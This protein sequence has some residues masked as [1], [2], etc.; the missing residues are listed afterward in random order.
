M[1]RFVIRSSTL[2]CTF[3][4]VSCSVKW[5]EIG[6]RYTGLPKDLRNV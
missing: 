1:F 4:D 3:Q 2:V 5:R 6:S